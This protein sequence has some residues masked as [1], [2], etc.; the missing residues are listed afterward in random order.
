MTRLQKNIEI[1]P[2]M[3]ILILDQTLATSIWRINR[4][5]VRKTCGGEYMG[6]KRDEKDYKDGQ[7]YT[8]QSLLICTRHQILLG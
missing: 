1:G 7:H 8:M 2:N 6:I 4:Q 5:R 3:C